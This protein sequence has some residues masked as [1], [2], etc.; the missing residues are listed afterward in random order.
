MAA[1]PMNSSEQIFR[2]LKTEILNLTLKPGEAISENQL[3]A[4]FHVSRTPI[5]S[6]LQRLA[7]AGLVNVVPYKGTYVTLLNFE[8]IQQIIYMRIAVESMVIRDFMEVCTPILEEKLRYII[9]KQTVLVQEEHFE[10]A[11]FYE[12][13]S[14]LH[15]VWFKAIQ[16]DRLWKLIQ[17][18]Q[19]NYTRFRMLDI[20]A[21]Q[22]FEQI[23]EEHRALFA[24]IQQRDKQAVEP[25]IRKHLNGGIY[26]LQERI[27]T[28]FK[29]Y[30]QQEEEKQ[31]IALRL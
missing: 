29:C 10:I 31:P 20:V 11:H 28:E 27:Q 24:I 6:V 3:C 25:L 17:R 14:Q 16:K 12:L 19:I 22:N 8:D 9:R 13:D 21:V 18:S 4:R 26:R 23:I 5:R 2:I 7:N 15:E 1:G 30:F